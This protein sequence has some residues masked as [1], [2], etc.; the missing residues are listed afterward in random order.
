MIANLNRFLSSLLTFLLFFFSELICQTQVASPAVWLFPNGTPQGTRYQSILSYPQ[1]LKNFIVKW[2]NNSIAGDVQI[3]VG[4]IINDAKIDEDFP[5]APNE[6]VAVVGGKIVVVDGKGFAHKSNSFGFPYIRNVSVLFDTLSNTFYPNPTSSLLIG[7]ETIEFENPK[8]MLLYT[9]IAGYDSKADTVA[10]IKRLILDM[11]EYKPNVYGSIKPFFG[12]R[13][14]KDFLVFAAVNTI[15]P[16]AK[17][18]DPVRAPF[19]RGLALFPS[20]NVVYTFPMPD[21]TDN[22]NFR[23]TLGPEISFTSPSL[24]Y[25]SGNFLCAVPNYPTPNLNCNIPSIV[26]LERTNTAKSYLLSYTFVNDQIRQTFPPLELNSILDNNGTRQRI[27]PIFVTLNNSYNSDSVY[28]LVAEEYSGIDSSMGISRLHLF[29]SKG[30]A[31]TLP[32]DSLSP[33]FVGLSNHHWSIAVGN[34]DGK[35]TNNFLPYYPNNPG[36]E[37][38][39]TYSSKFRMVPGNKLL[40][41]RYREGNPIPKTSPPYSYLFPFDTICTFSISGWVAA[42]NDLD[43]DTSGKD[44]IVLVNGSQ[45]LVLRLRDYNSFEFKIGKPFD[46]LFAKEF[47]SETIFDALIAD[48]DGDAKNDIVVLTNN[49]LY[50]I[51]SPLPKLIEVQTPKY[52]DNIVQEF[53]FGDTI[54]VVLNSKIKT[55]TNINLRFIPERNGLFDYKASFF[56]ANNIAISSKVVQVPIVADN[57]LV[58]KTGLIYVENSLDSSEVFDSTAIIRINP[59]SAAVDSSYLQQW[60]YLDNIQIG[61]FAKCIDTLYLEYLNTN[62][63]WELVDK[64]INPSPSEMFLVSLP[65]MQIFDYNGQ[66][67]N[68]KVDFRF[69]STKDGFR[70]TSLPFNVRVKPRNFLVYYDSSNTICCS[71]I[72]RWERLTGCDTIEI[73]LNLGAQYFKIAALPIEQSQFVLEQKRN[74]PDLLPLRFICR[75]NCLAVDTLIYISKPSIINTVAP[76]PFN[77]KTDV[78]EISYILTNDARVS[79]KILD[80]ANRLVK[81][82]ISSV[83]RQSNTYYCEYWDGRNYDGSL[84]DPGLYYIFLQLS[85]GNQEIFPIFVK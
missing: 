59:P 41:L 10:L 46:T 7:L 60:F 43:K 83:Q 42:V 39:A 30:N 76:N 81:E 29:D 37:I 84:V 22:P 32:N 6:I 58:G 74:Y 26:S 55:T 65:C 14:G 17:E 27:K 56:V 3:L 77:P 51:G 44:E 73:H 38:V 47:P 85:D 20:N 21:I 5:Y 66:E 33:S 24:F 50:L 80:A 79:V 63:K 31:V 52:S 57:R 12:R 28:I 35:S 9:Y 16:E 72:F 13:Y 45:L 25:S 1:D 67:I 82:L 61:C 75:K 34:V 68:G 64:R 49:Y 8:D 36:N 40:V 69:V 23:V 4:N 53:C 15:R 78:L 2:K 18:T 54:A 71:K 11:R 70:D 19:L 62:N 48:V